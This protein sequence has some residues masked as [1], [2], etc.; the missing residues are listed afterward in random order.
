[1]V[2]AN[3]ISPRWL[4]KH[5]IAMALSKNRQI[6]VLIVPQLKNLTKTLLKAPTII[7]GV[8]TKASS[9]ELDK[10]YQKL[11]IHEELLTNYATIESNQDVSIKKKKRKAKE[12]SI[13]PVTLLK[14]PADNSRAFIPMDVEEASQPPVAK[15]PSTGFIAFST[16]SIE[17]SKSFAKSAANVVYRPIKIKSMIGNPNRK[18]K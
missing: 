6:K 4:S 9:V 11:G 14:K 13:I 17:E 12:P 2:L 5:L 18:K 8:D 16:Q 3:E 7:F 1:M 15:P 10:F